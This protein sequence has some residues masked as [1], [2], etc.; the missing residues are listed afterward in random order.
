MSILLYAL[1]ALFFCWLLGNLLTGPLQDYF[2]FRPQKLAQDYTF[3][4]Q[5][6]R[7]EEVWLD[8][9]HRGGINALHFRQGAAAAKGVVLYFHGNASNLMRWGHLHHYFARFGY[10]YVVCD[11]RGFGKSAGPRSERA[12]YADA[13]AMYQYVQMHYEPAQIVIFG[14]SMG[15]AFACRVA[16]ESLVQRLVLETPFASMPNLFYTYYPFLPRVFMFK[17]RFPNRR[18]LAQVR[19]P[20]HIFQGTDDWVVPYTCAARLKSCLKPGDTFVSIPGGRHNN[21]L[22]YDIYNLK[23]EEILSK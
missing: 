19:C 10:D 23:M 11:Y 15:S 8:T 21:L 17:Y 14:R 13:Q 2:I 7:M 12:L 3:D 16:A 18:Y 22:F 5:S 4:F 1:A 9:P 20:V 6:T